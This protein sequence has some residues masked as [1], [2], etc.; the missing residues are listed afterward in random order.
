MKQTEVN[1]DAD[2]KA[3]TYVADDLL[4]TD[5]PMFNMPFMTR[6]TSRYR[7]SHYLFDELVELHKAQLVGSGLNL[8]MSTPNMPLYLAAKPSVSD[9]YKFT[10]ESWVFQIRRTHDS[11][12]QYTSLALKEKLPPDGSFKIETAGVADLVKNGADSTSVFTALLGSDEIKFRK[13]F[14]FLNII[15]DVFNAMKHHWVYEE[16]NTY[17]KEM[18]NVYVYYTRH[19]DLEKNGICVHN[20]NA[21]HLM[22]GFQDTVRLFLSNLKIEYESKKL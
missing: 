3:A 22:M 18:P 15:N 12:V 1:Y 13:I 2:R 5:F 4:M 11:I 9:K 20:H 19:N 16:V 14:E 6:I 8:V 10:V 17:R 21:F 7:F